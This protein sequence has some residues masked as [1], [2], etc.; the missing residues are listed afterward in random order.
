MVQENL[1]QRRLQELDSLR[2]LAAVYVVLFHTALVPVPPLVLPNGAERAILFGGT[3]VL[4]FFVISGFSLSMTMPRHLQAAS[5]ILSYGLSRFFRISPLFYVVLLASVIRDIVLFHYPLWPGNIGINALFLFNFFPGRQEGIAWASWTIG[6]EMVYYAVFPLLYALSIR[7]KMLVAAASLLGYW[8]MNH[9]PGMTELSYFSVVGF[10]P[11]FI[12]GEL[13][14]LAYDRLR[15][16][17]DAH[18]W[19]LALIACGAASLFSCLLVDHSEKSVSLRSLIGLGYASLLLGVTLQPIRLMQGR[20][21]GFYGTI[22]YS[23]Y[24][25]HAPIVYAL[26]PLYKQVYG[27]VPAGLA[28]VACAVATMAVAT[29]VAWLGYRCVERP[30]IRL[31]AKLSQAW[32]SRIFPRRNASTA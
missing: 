9:V 19:G 13:A 29:P 8:M 16:R 30:G 28:Y 14:F 27:A 31:G 15:L 10:I 3:G 7:S 20:V 17:A 6:V 24:L 12:F 23:L 26:S 22:S 11:V 25:C 1:R 21:F 5:P 2:G 4:L 18:V 32:M